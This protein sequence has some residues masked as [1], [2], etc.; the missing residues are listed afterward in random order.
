MKKMSKIDYV[1]QKYTYITTW[2]MLYDF[3][4]F[5]IFNYMY[6]FVLI[7]KDRGVINSVK[8]QGV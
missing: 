4:M 1:F 2:Y 6:I 8:N 5:I 7:I 3:E